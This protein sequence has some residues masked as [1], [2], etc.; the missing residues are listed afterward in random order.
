MLDFVGVDATMALGASLVAAARAT[1]RSSASAAASLPV[2]FFTVPYEVSL[3]TTY[4]GTLPEL[5]EVIALAPGVTST[6]W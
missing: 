6:R 3:A 5:Y 4:W 1:S 2:S